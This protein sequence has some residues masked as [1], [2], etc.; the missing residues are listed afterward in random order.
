[1]GLSFGFEH[2]AG[3]MSAGALAFGSVLS[4]E[5]T[6]V[7]EIAD[8]GA[9]SEQH[10]NP[11]VERVD[12]HDALAF[13]LFLDRLPYPCGHAL[14]LALVNDGS[15]RRIDVVRRAPLARQAVKAGR[16]RPRTRVEGKREFGI[17]PRIYQRRRDP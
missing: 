7:A 13:A 5:P 15:E 17:E 6:H 8:L 3:D 1:M 14:F 2:K 16:Q 12:H 11:L 9:S 10:E 4:R